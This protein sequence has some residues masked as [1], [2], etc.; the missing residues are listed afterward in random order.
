MW[1]GLLAKPPEYLPTQ[2]HT[3]PPQPEGRRNKVCTLLG[4]RDAD[5]FGRGPQNARDLI[6][7]EHFLATLHST[8]GH[9]RHHSSSGRHQRALR[10]G[11]KTKK[12]AIERSPAS[13]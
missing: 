3:T 9:S 13:P 7:V 5:S 10:A 11:G 8:R 6:S 1:T 12:P 2:P 4:D